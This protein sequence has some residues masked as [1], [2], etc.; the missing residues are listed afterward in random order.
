MINMKRWGQLLKGHCPVL[1][2]FK[3][4]EGEEWGMWGLPSSP[5]PPQYNIPLPKCGG[6]C[7]YGVCMEGRSVLIGG[8]E[9][10]AGR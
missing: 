4:I 2:P 6:V 1:F 5:L 9:V 3:A 10:G 7:M 8:S